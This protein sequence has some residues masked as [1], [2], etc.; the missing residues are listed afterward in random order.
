MTEHGSGLV[1]S[2][3]SYRA[4]FW[5]LLLVTLV[6]LWVARCLPCVDLPQHL[7]SVSIMRRLAVSN[8]GGAVAYSLRMYPTHNLLHLIL[9]YLLS[10]PGGIEL[11]AKLFFSAYV[12]AFGL[13]LDY[14]L[15]VLRADRWLG[16][17]ALLFVY[18][19]NFFWGFPGMLAAL[20][21]LLFVLALE[22]EWLQAGKQSV[23][24]WFLL[25]LV[26]V[27]GFLAHALG[28]ALMVVL[29]CV[30]LLCCQNGSRARKR[31][32]I[33]LTTLV[34]VL[35]L[36]VAPWLLVVDH[37]VPRVPLSQVVES[38][39]ESSPLARLLEV[40]LQVGSRDAVTRVLVALVPLTVVL[41]LVFAVR[42]RGLAEL[43]SMPLLTASCLAGACFAGYLL[44]PAR[45]GM[46]TILSD[47]FATFGYVFLAI[48]FGLTPELT[49][50]MRRAFPFAVA[51]ALLVNASNI[52]WRFW[53][54]DRVARPGMKMIDSLPADKSVLGLIYSD[55]GLRMF[56]YPVL[57]HFATYYPAL[58]GGFA[59]YTFAQMAYSPVRF[60]GQREFLA[61]GDEIA[62]WRH[63][64]PDGWSDYDY[65][66]VLGFPRLKDR[67]YLDRSFRICSDGLWCL[68]AVPCDVGP[69]SG[70]LDGE[71]RSTCTSGM[72]PE[73]PPTDCLP[74]ARRASSFSSVMSGLRVL[75]ARLACQ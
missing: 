19:F 64:F 12:I 43:R 40:D 61:T 27:V 39:R 75:V 49:G 65:V 14:L 52:A 21:L 37:G 7:D 28:L 33:L 26:W 2:Q 10:L 48:V 35:V 54:M 25:A 50:R 63:V 34:P 66:I 1:L 30:V 60:V 74:K 67:E 57:L 11:A 44:L 38:Y 16:L 3:P 5:S 41:R 13:A 15:R 68:Y 55:A 6:P 45:Y 69:N 20:P 58:R 36:F 46:I 8:S 62:P 71:S 4:V 59:G 23:I 56:G 22:L 17:T 29:F 31:V 24:R 32:G 42:R 18:N 70:G 9:M 47:R 72:H 51:I 73:G 53:S